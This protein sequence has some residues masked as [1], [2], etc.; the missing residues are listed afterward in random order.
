MTEKE[1]EI[2]NIKEESG[3]EEKN[4]KIEDNQSE[5]KRLKKEGKEDTNEYKKLKEETEKL[6]EETEKIELQI[7]PKIKIKQDELDKITSH[8]SDIVGEVEKDEAL[9]EFSKSLKGE[10]E[11]R[12]KL[13]DKID[14]VKPPKSLSGRA[15]TMELVQEKMKEV[16]GIDSNEE[17]TSYLRTALANRDTYTAMAIMKKMTADG[18]DNEWLNAITDD[19]GTAYVSDAVGLDRFIRERFMKKSQG[20]G[21]GNLGLTEQ[22]SLAFQNEI[23][24]GAEKV[25]HWEIA[26]TIITDAAGELKSNIKRLD[27]GGNEIKDKKQKAVSYD[28]SRHV[29]EAFS[30]IQKIEPQ[31][32]ARILNRLAYGGEKMR[33]DGKGRDF[34]LSNLGRVLLYDM[35]NSA[36]FFAN[37]TR[38]NSSAAQNLSIKHVQ[39]YIRSIFDKASADN[40]INTITRVGTSK[41]GE[42]LNPERIVKEF[43]EKKIIE[44]VVSGA[45][46]KISH[47]PLR[48]TATSALGIAK[49]DLKTLR[50]IISSKKIGVDISPLE[51]FV[52]RLEQNTVLRFKPREDL[53][54]DKTFNETAD[55]EKEVLKNIIQKVK[56]ELSDKTFEKKGLNGVI[57]AFEKSL[58]ENKK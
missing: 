52:N 55:N 25:G 48:E 2:K 28:D 47:E 27:K 36:S 26:R 31:M 56:K 29:F 8:K 53:N 42:T 23:S 1:E 49:D 35:G 41:E 32:R 19:D 58:K 22:E 30:E 50:G 37:A 51:N 13:Q 34:Q 46:F 43:Q 18:N 24:Y 6:K 11:E 44:S 39:D 17:L 38:L 15:A 14:R 3:L 45:D 4:K 5:L 16:E 9:A 20:G 10:R 54:W 40:F 7:E 12:T 21:K 57:S 33:P